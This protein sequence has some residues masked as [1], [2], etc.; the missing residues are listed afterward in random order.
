MIPSL[1]KLLATSAGKVAVGVVV[2]TTSVGAAAAAGA[3]IPFVTQTEQSAEIGDDDQSEE[4]VEEPAPEEEPAAEPVEEPEEEPV[5]ESEEEFRD[6]SEE[7]PAP[8]EESAGDEAEDAESDEPTHGDVVSGFVHETELEGCWKGQATA[9]VAR[10]DIEPDE[11]GAIDPAAVDEY[12]GGLDKCG[13][14]YGVDDEEVDAA[15]LDEDEG[16]ESPDDGDDEDGD[17]EDRGK[18]DHA[19][20]RGSERSQGKA[21]GHDK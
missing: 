15:D 1:T 4:L 17:D 11:T 21:K 2:A 7:E 3:E 13:G 20:Q 14:D 10:G 5:D 18:P 12:L 9:A 19:G 16:Q 6:E 8:E